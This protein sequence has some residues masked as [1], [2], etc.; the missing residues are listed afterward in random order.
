VNE[1]TFME[2]LEDRYHV[3]R[4]PASD[5]AISLGSELGASMV[6]TGAYVAVTGIIGL[7]AVIEG[8]RESVPSYR[9]QHIAANETAL[10]AGFDA[11]DAG[12]YPA[13]EGAPV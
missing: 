9:T 5:I 6:M 10:R 13:W 8:M 12:S 4:V 2:P 1:A 3:L 7:D 11:V